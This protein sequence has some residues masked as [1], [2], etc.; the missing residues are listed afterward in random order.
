MKNIFYLLISLLLACA[1]APLVNML[2]ILFGY[3]SLL[4]SVAPPPATFDA[5]ARLG[6][7]G[8][9]FGGHTAAFS[10]LL[11]ACILIHFSL[12]Q[13]KIAKQA[14]D[15]TSIS[16]IYDHYNEDYSSQQTKQSMILSGVAR[17]HRRWAIRESFSIIDPDSALE[18][19]RSRQ[20]NADFE[21]LVALSGEPD[22]TSIYPSVAILCGSLLLD[23]R[24]IKRKRVALWP[25]YENLRND[26]ADLENLEREAV[27][28]LASN[29][30]KIR[31][32]FDG[33]F[34]W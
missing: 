3:S 18:A 8:D 5:M 26:A 28:K 27:E 30:R 7:M 15:L 24:L 11:S 29:L 4:K 21:Q 2:A 22:N 25:L 20:V 10:G 19:E 17:G 23:K 1:I 12:Q 31:R 33:G 6:Q 16:K 32:R 13:T 14:A 34:S 9:F